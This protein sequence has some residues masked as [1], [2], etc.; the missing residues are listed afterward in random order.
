[1]TV[2]LT[3]VGLGVLLALAGWAGRRNAYG[4][5][6][7]PGMPA[8]HEAHRIRVIRRGATVCLVVGVTFVVVGALAPWL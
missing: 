2:V 1:V 4:L 7:V 8:E 6:A 5:G 3:F